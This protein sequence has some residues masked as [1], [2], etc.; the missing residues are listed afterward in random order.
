M[1]KKSNIKIFIFTVLFLVFGFCS[2]IFCE[3]ETASFQIASA[4]DDLDK[5]VAI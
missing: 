1:G 3:T 2:K 5:D 4:Q